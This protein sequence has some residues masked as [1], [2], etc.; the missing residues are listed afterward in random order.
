MRHHLLCGLA[1][2]PTLPSDTSVAAAAAA[3]P[4][5]PSA[6]MRRLLDS[7]GRPVSDRAAGSPWSVDARAGQ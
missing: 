6:V 5:P 7:G 4:A 1:A 2:S 3:N